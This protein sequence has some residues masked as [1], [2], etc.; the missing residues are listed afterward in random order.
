MSNSKYHFFL[1]GPFSQW[2]KSNM[3]CT[4][5]LL[6]NCC[7]QF[8]MASKAVT[9]NDERAFNKICDASDPADQKRLGRDVKN[10][11]EEVWAKKRL[12]VVFMGN[13]LKFTQ[14]ETLKK[15][16]LSTEDKIL[17]ECNP[18]DKIWGIGLSIAD[19]YQVTEKEWKGKNYLGKVLMLVRECIATNNVYLDRSVY[20]IFCERGW[21]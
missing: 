4:H 3:T 18:R 17:V 7:E 12:D 6:W 19:A 1:S 16:I 11:N 9:F 20:D 21:L 13:M 8:M 2:Y 15:M 5:G 14:N 10:Y